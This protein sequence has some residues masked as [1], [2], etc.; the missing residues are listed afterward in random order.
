MGKLTKNSYTSKQIEQI[1][2]LKSRTQH[3]YV[4][5]GILAPCI[6]GAS[7]TGTVRLYSKANLIEAKLISYLIELGFPKRLISSFFADIKKKAIPFLGVVCF[8]PD[9][10]I[11]IEIK[12]DL[13]ALVRQ[14]NFN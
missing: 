12:V 11:P 9:S 10:S 13:T 4:E 1:T 2:G 8:K 14:L 3:V 5:A 7:G 6:Q